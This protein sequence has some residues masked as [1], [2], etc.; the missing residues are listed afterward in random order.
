M[1]VSLICYKAVLKLKVKKLH[2]M[3]ETKNT[4]Q[5]LIEIALG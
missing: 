5:N 3:V 2:A 4:F 1:P